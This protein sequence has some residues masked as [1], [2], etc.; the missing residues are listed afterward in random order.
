MM[1]FS[2]QTSMCSNFRMQGMPHEDGVRVFGTTAKSD[3]EIIE[4]MI[5]KIQ[6]HASASTSATCC[7]S[8]FQTPPCPVFFARPA[9]SPGVVAKPVATLL[10]DDEF[11]TTD[12][13]CSEH[14]FKMSRRQGK[15]T[16]MVRNMP[17]MYTQEM[18][19]EEWKYAGKFDFL[20]LPRTANGQTNLS[21]AFINF[22]SEADALAFQ[23]AWHKQRVAQFTSRKPLSISFAEVQ[24]LQ[25]NLTQHRK[26]RTRCSDPKQ[27]QP[28]VLV[29]DQYL[30]VPD[31][32]QYVS[33]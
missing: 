7:Q 26:K 4:E 12:E 10:F 29:G 15:T 5:A 14:P 2:Q 20:Y 32:L 31:A 27:C 13:C 25:E 24:G 11:S 23:A 9:G 22:E 8:A 17:V 21:Y 19:L 28:L 18:L 33:F 6:V 1:C 3:A 16:L 30:S